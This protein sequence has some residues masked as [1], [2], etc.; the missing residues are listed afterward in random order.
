MHPAEVVTPPATDGPQAG[1]PPSAIPWRQRLKPLAPVAICV[2]VF[3][4]VAPTLRWLEFCNGMENTVTATVLQAKRGHGPWWVPRLNEGLRTQKPPLAVWVAATG[5]K[6]STV[7]DLSGPDA[8][9]GDGA[10]MT[11]AWEMRWTAL[12]A[13]CLMLLA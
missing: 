5:V 7:Q 10:Y 12:L 1:T 11:L 6:S 2:A 4:A 8:L 3:L 13:G 9:L